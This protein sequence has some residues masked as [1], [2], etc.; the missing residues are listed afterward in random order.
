MAARFFSRVSSALTSLA[1]AARTAAPA[2]ETTAAPRHG[3]DFSPLISRINADGESLYPRP[4]ACICDIRGARFG[5]QTTETPP[6]RLTS[7]G[8]AG[9]AQVRGSGDGKPR[10]AGTTRKR[11]ARRPALPLP[12]VPCIP[13]FVLCFFA[14]TPFGCGFASR[15]LGGALSGAG[16]KAARFFRRPQP[17]AGE[18][19]FPQTK[20][21]SPPWRPLPEPLLQPV[22]PPRPRGTERTF[23]R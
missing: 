17:L 18:S 8:P 9:A 1:S 2:S 13:W 5:W 3:E 20:W 21:P 14:V 6:G 12:C 7:R 23:H 15:C 11:T 4:A 19:V 10:Q 16:T 22:K